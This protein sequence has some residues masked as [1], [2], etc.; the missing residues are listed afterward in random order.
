MNTTLTERKQNLVKFLFFLQKLR[1]TFFEI[2]NCDRMQNVFNCFIYERSLLFL[3]LVKF[4]FN[5]KV[6]KA[7][8]CQ[9]SLFH[10][11]IILATK[12]LN[13]ILIFYIKWHGSA[14]FCFLINSIIDHFLPSHSLI[15][16]ISC[17]SYSSLSNKKNVLLVD[18][19]VK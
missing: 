4:I 10:K 9:S 1:K 19:N 17:D 7:K 2:Q 12:I 15:F 8:F 18:S 13:N 6:R 14:L 3:F 11:V 16:T 5:N